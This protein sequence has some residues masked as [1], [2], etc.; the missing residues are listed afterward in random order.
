MGEPGQQ[1][2]LLNSYP[3]LFAADPGDFLDF[4]EA[5][6]DGRLWRYFINPG[7]FYSLGIVLKG[8]E[9]IENPFAIDYWSTTAFYRTEGVQ[10]MGAKAGKHYG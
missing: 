10:T 4:I 5:S 7:H 1:D 3:V 8:R 2:F 6:R 9:E